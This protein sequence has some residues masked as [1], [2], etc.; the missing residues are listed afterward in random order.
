MTE[1]RTPQTKCAEEDAHDDFMSTLE[2][3]YP[4]AVREAC[5]FGQVGFHLGADHGLLT[6]AEKR[7][8][9]IE[10]QSEGLR[11]E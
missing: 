2:A 10:L 6:G 11:S 5:L 8:C 3:V 4:T 1:A 7:S 9:L